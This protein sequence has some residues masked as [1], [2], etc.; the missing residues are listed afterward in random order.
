MSILTLL[1]N[2][3]KHEK[4]L[5]FGSAAQ[6]SPP[7]AVNFTSTQR[8]KIPKNNGLIISICPL[9][10]S[11]DKWSQSKTIFSSKINILSLMRHFDHFQ[12]LQV[13]K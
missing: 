4:V 11:H 1:H 9:N 3:I 6:N 12:R 8:L 7:I 10:A 5:H 2:S 13:H